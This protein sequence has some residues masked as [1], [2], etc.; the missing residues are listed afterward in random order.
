[1]GG[2]QNTVLVVDD[3]AALRLLCRVS[4]EHEGFRVLEAGTVSEARQALRDEAVDA[5]LLDVHVGA[6]DG[7][8]FLRELRAQDAPV[9]I[10]LLSGSAEVATLRQE[11]VDVIRKPFR[12]DEL[13]EVVRK[14]TTRRASTV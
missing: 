13:T 4:L 6:D 8:A 12:L 1:M 3:E 5:V 2:A 11:G 7:L 14:L 9:G 10:A